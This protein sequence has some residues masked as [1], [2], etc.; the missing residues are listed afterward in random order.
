[1]GGVTERSKLKHYE[2][3]QKCKIRNQK[4]K[5]LNK[6][7]ERCKPTAEQQPILLDQ[8]EDKTAMSEEVKKV[9]KVYKKLL[10]KSGIK[11]RTSIVRRM[12]ES[13]MMAK[14]LSGNVLPSMNS[15]FSRGFSKGLDHLQSESLSPE[16]SIWN[17]TDWDPGDEP[18]TSSADD[19][20]SQARSI[21]FTGSIQNL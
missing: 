15:K 19:H 3:N 7:F 16:H 6:T 11:N 2:K 5:E 12:A 21:D 20:Y 1:M 8:E 9:E 13:A 14:C 4:N 18:T 17:P 10:P